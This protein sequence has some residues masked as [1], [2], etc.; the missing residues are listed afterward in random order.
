[1]ERKTLVVLVSLLMV[2]TVPIAM[3]AHD[4]PQI[5]V[6][7]HAGG[8]YFG[9][10]YDP[11]QF[12]GSATYGFP[13]YSYAWHF[14]DGTS[15]TGQT[16]YKAFSSAG[17]YTATLTVTD[18]KGYHDDSI[19]SVTV[20]VPPYDLHVDVRTSGN[21]HHYS[22]GDVVPIILDITNSQY[23]QGPTPPFTYTCKIGETVLQYPTESL[24][25]EPGQSIHRT[26]AWDADEWGL[27]IITAQ[28]T[29]DTGETISD[30]WVIM[31]WPFGADM[32]S[33]P[34]D[35]VDGPGIPYPI[36]D[37]GPDDPIHL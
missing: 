12:T 28:V 19:A 5:H 10:I 7:A 27:Y 20:E 13:P 4:E 15:A 17:S 9:Y 36:P 33:D 2:L 30:S 3:A 21:V 35:P 22:E 16:V 1:M 24:G 31:V 14:S 18:S 29:L 6:Q 25:L 32:P 26:Y 34:T 8:P 23:A 11:I 37:P